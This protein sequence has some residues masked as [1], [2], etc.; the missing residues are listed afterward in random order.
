MKEEVFKNIKEQLKNYKFSSL[1]Y[2]EYEDILD[3]DVICKDKEIILIFG[4]NKEAKLEEFHWVAN[5]AFSLLQEI[6]KLNKKGLITFIPEEWINEFKDNNFH[7]YAV[8]NDYFNNDISKSFECE[9][10]MEFLEECHCKEASEVTLSCRDQSRG[11][12]GQTE[13]WMKQWIQG[14]EPSLTSSDCKGSAILLH[15]EDGNIAGIVCV[16]TYAHDSEKGAI[17]WVREIA[18]RPEYQRRG[19]AKKL[20]TQALS[21]G[22]SHGAKR[23]FLMAD[24]CNDH[25]INLYNNMGF[26]ANK[27]ETQNDMILK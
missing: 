20:L 4:Y 1:K 12:S 2:T 11:F 19:I 5:S 10:A 16:T 26:V 15:R 8:W 18:V 6:S 17:L 25:A 13:E 3:Y 14:V 21:Y 27:D 24:E 9:E 22:K 7:M 23:A